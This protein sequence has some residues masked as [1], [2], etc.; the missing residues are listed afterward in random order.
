[1]LDIVPDG[2]TMEGMSDAAYWKLSLRALDGARKAKVHS[3]ALD[4]LA[5]KVDEA[6]WRMV[7]DV[8]MAEAEERMQEQERNL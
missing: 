4:L 1:M 2:A 7:R 3:I 6:N 8:A 5:A